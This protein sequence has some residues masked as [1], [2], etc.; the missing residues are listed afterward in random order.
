M[1][2][3]REKHRTVKVQVGEMQADIDEEIAPLIRELW[4]AGIETL[5]SCQDNP[6]GFVWVQ[7]ATTTDAAAFLDI[8]AQYDDEPDGLYARITGRCDCLDD[9]PPPWQY[10]AHPEDYCLV[11][12]YTDDDGEVEYWHEGDPEFFFWMSVRFPRSDYPTVLARLVRYNE[13]QEKRGQAREADDA[14]D[15]A[16]KPESCSTPAALADLAG[17]APVAAGG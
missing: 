14:G 5:N 11:E 15:Q 2:R 17:A 13:V 8:V 4:E 6:S 1:V 16:G 3:K 9:S 10:H 12:G 7:F